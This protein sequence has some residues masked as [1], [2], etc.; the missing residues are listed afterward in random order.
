MHQAPTA[1]A[2][3]SMPLWD[4]TS[5]FYRAWLPA[6]PSD[7]AVL[8]FHRGHE[9]SGRLEDVVDRLDLADLN[10]FAW[11]A[12]GHG[13]SPG[14]RG[15]AESFG[16]MVKDVDSFVRGVSER[17]GVAIED[18]AVLAHS[19]GAVTIATWV[20]DFAP[21]IRALVL[22][23]PAFRVKLYVPLAIPGLRVLH[24]VRGT[25]FIK[26]YVKGRMLTHDAE[27]AAAYHRDPLVSRNIA[28]NIL[29]GLHDASTRLLADAAA[30]ATPTLVQAAGR[31]WVVKRSPQ[32]KLFARLS[33]TVK[34]F[35][36]YPEMFHAILHET[37]R[38]LPIADARRFM[39]DAFDRQP[40][41]PSRR[42][43]DQGTA[44]ATKR[45]FLERSAPVWQRPYWWASRLFLRSVGRLSQGITIGWRNGF[46]SGQS[47]DHVYG[48]RARG[49][50]PLGRLIDRVYLDAPG[51][52]GIRTRRKNI[53]R[54]LRR[55]MELVHACGDPVHILDVASGPGRYVL[56]A[57]AAEP[58]FAATATLR[59]RDRDGLAQGRRLAIEHG[60]QDRVCYEEGDA[61]DPSS[62]GACSPRP[63]IGVVCGLLELF[64]GN[65][66]ARDCLRGLGRAVQDG[67]YLV[68]TNQPWHP[69][70]VMIA[71]VLT[72]RDGDPWIMRCRTQLEMDQLV[73]DAG[74][75]KIAMETDE[76]GI[77]TVSLARKTGRMRDDAP[78]TAGTPTTASHRG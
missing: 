5:V 1:P 49:V 34:A 45:A 11:D 21:P 75:E 36:V 63:T 35:K 58:R 6:T 39:L 23:T 19:V 28:V 65:G 76:D 54:L 32:E 14:E 12:R 2:E 72:N 41:P 59:D 30:I 16:A 56:E 46:D 70:L 47:L 67:G 17:H 51:W 37:D 29:L 7:R 53:E 55:A 62:V 8:L 48:N 27:I 25:C 20:H 78:T 71:R 52:K 77:F 61:L 3:L 18:M 66:A 26:S 13:R 31:D 15:Y 9:H 68:Y 69:Q 57:I 22:A 73:A 50:S 42:D 64:P 10:V 40:G 74:F 33:S 4:G 24:R 38:H 60:L 43:D 44:A